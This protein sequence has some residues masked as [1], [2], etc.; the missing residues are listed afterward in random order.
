MLAAID[1]A[2]TS[3]N[4]LSYIFDSDRSG[5]QFL[6]ALKRACARGVGVRVLIDSVGAATGSMAGLMGD[7]VRT[8]VNDD[9]LADV[10]ETLTPDLIESTVD[11]IESRVKAAIPAVTRICIEAESFQ[12]P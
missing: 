10:L 11:R 4:L 7:A 6:A 1:E 2:T 5:E 9:F 8:G 12:K 3:V